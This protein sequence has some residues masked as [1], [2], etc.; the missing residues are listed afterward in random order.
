MKF[1][2]QFIYMAAVVIA[3]SMTSMAQKNDNQNRPVKPDPP[4]IDPKDKP[5]PEKPP[6]DDGNRNRPNK[7]QD[8]VSVI[9][10]P[11]EISSV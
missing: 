11:A 9:R 4:K 8:S 3:L 5:K 6:R 7:P 1:L 2:K 10:I